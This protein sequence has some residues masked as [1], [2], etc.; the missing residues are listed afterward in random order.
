MSDDIKMVLEKM[1]DGWILRWERSATKEPFLHKRGGLQD[2]IIEVNATTFFELIEL[3][4]V[5][6]MGSRSIIEYY[7]LTKKGQSIKL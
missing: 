2:A 3:G 6:A 1:R 7:P 5:K 4:L